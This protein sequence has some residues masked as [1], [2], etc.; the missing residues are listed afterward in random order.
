MKKKLKKVANVLHILGQHP[1]S[2]VQF[3]R[4]KKISAKAVNIKPSHEI[5]K[6]A[7]VHT[8]VSKIHH[9]FGEI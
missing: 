9:I 6:T 4:E 2:F 3:F 5:I 1:V 7:T 8:N